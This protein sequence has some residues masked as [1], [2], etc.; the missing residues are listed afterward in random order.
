MAMSWRDKMRVD[1]SNA[2]I[3]VTEE[4]QRQ[5]VTEL[6]RDWVLVFTVTGIIPLRKEQITR[7]MVRTHKIT[8][9]DW[10]AR[11][12]QKPIYL[13]GYFVHKSLRRSRKDAEINRLLT[14][15]GWPPLRIPYN[16]R[17]LSHEKLT[18]VVG[19]IKEFL[20]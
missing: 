2:E 13:D 18:E 7:A 12:K 9:P 14:S 4:L 16:G 17:R 1:P 11:N 20:G 10:L 5:G 6:E 19:E 3:Q 15:W 8:L